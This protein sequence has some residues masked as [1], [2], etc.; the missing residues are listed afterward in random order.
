MK[1][2]FKSHCAKCVFIGRVFTQLVDGKP[3]DEGDLYLNCDYPAMG[4]PFKIQCSDYEPD[5]ITTDVDRLR[6]RLA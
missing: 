5:Y 3:A 4:N 2:K 1:P 6:M